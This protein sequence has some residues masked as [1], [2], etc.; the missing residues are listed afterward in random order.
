M[1]ILAID[2]TTEACSAALHING[3][4]IEK[5]EV[6]PRKHAELILPM[7]DSLLAESEQSLNQLDALAFA[8]G[9][10]A[11]TGVRLCTSV[12]QGLAYSADL[13]VI[14]VSTLAAL[15]QNSPIHTGKLFA[16]IDARMGEIYWALYYSVDNIVEALTDEKVKKPQELN[17]E[18]D[19]SCFGVGTGWGQYSDLL[20][21]KIGGHYIGHDSSILPS[22]N[23]V[24]R[25]AIKDYQKGKKHQN[26]EALPTYLRNS[27]V[28]K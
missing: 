8:R 18:V 26:F 15:A 20:S 6:A 28:T 7:I 24:I 22:S 10:G 25:L 16:A 23:S 17:I 3:E 1:R 12:A 9:P 11:F 2:T 19:E 21:D 4:T 27:V 5:Y 14:P 13:P